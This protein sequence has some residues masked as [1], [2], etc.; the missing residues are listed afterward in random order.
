MTLR[1]I[2]DLLGLNQGP[3]RVLI[4][5]DALGWAYRLEEFLIESGH[6]VTLF[7]GVDSM[8]NGQI[9]GIVDRA[10]RPLCTSISDLD[11]AFLDHYFAGLRYNGTLLTNELIQIH[12]SLKI[13][14]MSSVNEA[15]E[16]MRRAGAL[17]FL[18]KSQF[19]RLL[20]AKL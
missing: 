4:V 17:E 1:T 8:E 5:E 13:F 19:E 12:P 3:K 20:P 2:T 15:N 9:R 11:V 7:V 14:G 18:K 10:G 16:S 6:E